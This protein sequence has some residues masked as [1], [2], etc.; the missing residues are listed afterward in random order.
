ML[1]LAGGPVHVRLAPDGSVAAYTG[2]VELGQGARTELIQ[3]VAEEMRVGVERVK[4]VMGDT[5][6]CPDDGGTWGSLTTPQTVPAM[7]QAAAEARGGGLTAPADWKV[8]GQSLKNVRGRDIVTGKQKYASD[9]KVEGML[10][11]AVVR[12]PYHRAKLLSVGELPGARVLWEGDLV[13]VVAADPVTAAAGA[14]Q[15]KVAWEPGEFA[16]PPS[17]AE[18][19]GSFFQTHSTPPV[20]GPGRYPP[21]IRKGD[22]RG[23]LERAGKTKESRYWLPYLAHVPM[24]PRAAVAVWKDGAVEILSGTQAPFSVRSEVAKA[25]GIAESQVRIVVMPPGGAFG[26][27]QRGEVDVEAARLARLAGAPVRVAWTREEEFTA[28]YHR[29]AGLVVIESALDSEGKLAAW[30]HRNYAAGAPGLPTPYDTPHVSCEFHRA[31]SPVR[32]G[33]YRALAATAN[34]FARESHMDEWARELKVEPLAFRRKNIADARLLAV[35][36]QLANVPGGLACTIEKDARIGLRAQV[37][38][39]GK[40]IR[41]R[42]LVYVGDYGAVLNPGNLRNQ[43]MGA[44]V[45][46]LGGALFEE[47]E[48]EGNAQTS[49][50][51]TNYRVPRFSDV[52]EIEIRLLDH[53]EI[54]AAGAGEAAIILVAPAIAN[55]VFAA[56]GRRLRSLPL[57]L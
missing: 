8:L 49:R 52:P 3:A 14:A 18:K 5:G 11:A 26:G 17:D 2:K 35:L 54:E 36:E 25:L 34:V 37:E 57:K 47:V 6:L 50:F 1:L 46:G 30:V 39:R 42:K 31:P 10:H 44:L 51:L 9:T 29:P 4:L 55:A 32:Q 23:E 13:A 41:V 12:P 43:I 33:S 38:V 28:G 45:M 15:L 19:L 7:R 20:E 24:E 40:E 56:T 16:A 21:L 53:R 22:A 27:K 48:F